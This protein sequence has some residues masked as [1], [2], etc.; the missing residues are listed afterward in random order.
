MS[1]VL[2]YLTIPVVATM[3]AATMGF[4]LVLPCAAALG[5]IW[6]F[7]TYGSIFLILGGG[8]R[9]RGSWDCPNCQLIN[10]A[11]TLV[12]GCGERAPTS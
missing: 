11:T 4:N 2:G 6:V 8:K 12:C 5:W 10:K 9:A 3:I 7:L 1:G